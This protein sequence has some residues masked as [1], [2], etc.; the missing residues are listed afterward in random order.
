MKRLD[1]LSPLSELLIGASRSVLIFF[2][3]SNNFSFLYLSLYITFESET[4]QFTKTF[5]I[6]WG[7]NCLE[8]LLYYIYTFSNNFY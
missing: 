5:E 3:P 8:F 6:E 2:C 4:L 1:F 7:K